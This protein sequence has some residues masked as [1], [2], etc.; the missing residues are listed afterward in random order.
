MSAI[1]LKTAPPSREITEAMLLAM[2]ESD[3]MNR[4][5]LDFFRRRLARLREDVL[6]RIAAHSDDV[7]DADAPDP[8]DRASVVEQ[9]Y[10]AQRLNERD[11]ALLHK[12]DA[13]L[14][15]MRE[16]RYGYC[17]KTG[18]PIGIA[19]L[20]ARP[21]AMQAIEEKSRREAQDSHYVRRADRMSE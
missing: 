4:T 19:R 3:Y 14:Q 2:P 21:M 12:L 7:G 9:R 16:G 17:E 8:T 18:E 10:V 1:N 13:A 15:R 11:T 5:Q 20:L 6:N